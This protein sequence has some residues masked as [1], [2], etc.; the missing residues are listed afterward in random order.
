MKNFIIQFIFKLYFQFSEAT[1]FPD[2]AVAGDP[3]VSAS[4][5]VQAHKVVSSAIF[6]LTKKCYQEKEC[7]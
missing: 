4:L 7:I 6:S 2:R 3:V 1:L 5:N